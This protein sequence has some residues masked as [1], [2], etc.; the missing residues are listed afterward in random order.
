MIPKGKL[1]ALLAIFAALGVVTATGAFTTVSADRTAD[2]DVAG[3]SSALLQL[4][5]GDKNPGYVTESGGTIELNL[6]SPN[7]ASG[8]NLN[9]TTEIEG[10]INIT[11][12]GGQT[13]DVSIEKTGNNAQYVN[14]YQGDDLDS[15]TNITGA[16][17]VSV[18]SGDTIEVSMNIST[19]S[20]SLAD[21]DELL[22]DITIV[23]NGTES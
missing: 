2:V 10:V 14:F 23:A 17:S 15:A 13:V 12:N 11:N 9:A 8:A 21:G 19:D 4:E 1:L 3:D 20:S 7:S 5:E 6:S 22:S 16:N 18:S